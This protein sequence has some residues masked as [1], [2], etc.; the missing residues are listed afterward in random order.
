[1]SSKRR[2]CTPAEAVVQ[3]DEVFFVRNLYSPKLVENVV[4]GDFLKNGLL[5]NDEI[6]LS[7]T[8]SESSVFQGSLTKLFSRYINPKKK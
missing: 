8:S 5:R 7:N 2:L 4:M 6:G 1:M 3:D